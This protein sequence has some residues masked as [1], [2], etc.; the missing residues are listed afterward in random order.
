MDHGR[1]SELRVV[2][3]S[4]ADDDVLATEKLSL[5]TY[6]SHPLARCYNLAYMF[7]CSNENRS[8]RMR[9]K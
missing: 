4:M 8:K 7:K 9:L 3:Q 6:T 1:S 5:F 2:E